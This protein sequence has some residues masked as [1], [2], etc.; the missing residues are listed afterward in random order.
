MPSAAPNTRGIAPATVNGNRVDEIKIAPDTPL[1]D[2]YD[3]HFG[4][5]VPRLKDP[6]AAPDPNTNPIHDL[7]KNLDP[8]NDQK[9]AALVLGGWN[10]LG[11]RTI[12]MKRRGGRTAEHDFDHHDLGEPLTVL[13]DTGLTTAKVGG[14]NQKINIKPTK[15]HFPVNAKLGKTLLYSARNSVRLFGKGRL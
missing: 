10:G 5:N 9:D 13:G 6:T 3:I 8:D 14:F 2:S 15:T 11:P 7:Y 4:I 1:N 12:E